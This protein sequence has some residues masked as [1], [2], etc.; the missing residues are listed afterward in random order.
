MTLSTCCHPN[1]EF[2]YIIEFSSCWM[3]FMISLKEKDGILHYGSACQ[4]L[5]AGTINCV[6][7]KL[8]TVSFYPFVN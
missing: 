1:L 8:Y 4:P 2:G 5:F 3:N 6:Q 7:I